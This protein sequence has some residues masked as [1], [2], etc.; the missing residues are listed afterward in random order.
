MHAFH[1]K[2]TMSLSENVSESDD[3]A[4][5]KNPGH[6]SFIDSCA[7]HCTACSVEED[8]WNGNKFISSVPEKITPANAIKAWFK[9]SL[10]GGNNHTSIVPHGFNGTYSHIATNSLLFLQDFPYPCYSCCKCTVRAVPYVSSSNTKKS[11]R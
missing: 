6:G 8:T 4:S 10:P 3:L 5:F 1:Y 7:H 2:S 9:A 11:L